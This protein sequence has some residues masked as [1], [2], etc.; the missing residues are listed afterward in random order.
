VLPLY[1]LCVGVP[2][3]NPDLKPRLA[4]DAVLHDDAYQDDETVLA[5]IEDYDA[6]CRAYYRD[7]TG[8]ERDWSSGM[9]RKFSQ[10]A[11]ESLSP[12]YR[13]KGASFD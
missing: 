2:A 3:E 6:V 7:R 12:Y 4:P 1:G 9:A 13:S 8:T 11:R 10:P 5:H